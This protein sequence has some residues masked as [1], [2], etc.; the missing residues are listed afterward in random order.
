MLSLF[1][2]SKSH[3]AGKKLTEGS[4]Y[5]IHAVTKKKKEKEKESYCRLSMLKAVAQ[6]H[7]AD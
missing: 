5:I 3:M 1:I 2:S 7:Q 6:T 4:F